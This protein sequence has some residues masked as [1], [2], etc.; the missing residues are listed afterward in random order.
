MVVVFTT[1]CAISVCHNVV[2]SNPIHGEVYSIQHYVIKFGTGIWN[3]VESGAN[4]QLLT[5][6]IKEIRYV[7]YY[8][9]NLFCRFPDVPAPD[10]YLYSY[11]PCYPF[12]E[13]ACADQSVSTNLF[14]FL[15]SWGNDERN[16]ELHRKHCV[17][18]GARWCTISEW[19]VGYFYSQ[20]NKFT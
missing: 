6:S 11:N 7:S 8:R 3:I 17:L 10:N 12:A 14:C 1:T 18:Y 16:R 13:F 15:T 9:W 19:V 5:H 2:S 20:V 4:Q